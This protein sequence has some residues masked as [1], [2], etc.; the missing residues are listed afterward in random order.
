MQYLCWI[1]SEYLLIYG[2]DFLLTKEGYEKLIIFT[3]K[4]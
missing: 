1:Y 3:I 4:K 2:Y